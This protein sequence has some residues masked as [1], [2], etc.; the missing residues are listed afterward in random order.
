MHLQLVRLLH[1][2][3]SELNS[4]QD[5]VLS[6]SVKYAALKSNAIV[7]SL[8]PGGNLAATSLSSPHLLPCVIY[9]DPGLRVAT[10]L[11]CTAV[12][13]AVR[14]NCLTIFCMSVLFS[15]SSQYTEHATKETRAN[16]VP[17]SDET[18]ASQVEEGV[19]DQG[20]GYGC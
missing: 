12:C 18:E 16:L 7:S 15:I 11:L 13:T 17:G 14:T 4:I 9:C 5:N 8:F 1:F 2:R 20:Y 6:Q 3:C 19:G 10:E